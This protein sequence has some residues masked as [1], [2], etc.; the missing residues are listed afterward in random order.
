MKVLDDG[1]SPKIPL[2]IGAGG[3]SLQSVW[4]FGARKLGLLLAGSG[5]RNGQ[6]ACRE[7]QTQGEESEDTERSTP[8][9]SI[10]AL[11]SALCHCPN[12]RPDFSNIT[13]SNS[14]R[15]RFCTFAHPP[16]TVSIVFLVEFPFK[17]LS[18]TSTHPDSHPQPP[19]P[20]AP[21]IFSRGAIIA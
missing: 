19:D 10:C 18:S 12:P 20:P 15:L 7:L 2:R 13:T 9:P 14:L 5:G 1:T 4:S 6:R 16:S 3:G 17:P 11:S 8:R 21:R